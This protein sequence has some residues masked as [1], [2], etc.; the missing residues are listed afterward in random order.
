MSIEAPEKPRTIAE[1]RIDRKPYP[2]YVRVVRVDT[3]EGI[4]FRFEMTSN[5]T[6][7][8]NLHV[9]Y[10]DEEK[11]MEDYRVAIRQSSSQGQIDADH[12]RT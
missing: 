6:M 10:D 7:S 11:A 8:S 4:K 5:A 3:F 1:H 12:G 2:I 9:L